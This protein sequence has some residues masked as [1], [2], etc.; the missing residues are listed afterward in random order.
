M[1]RPSGRHSV[2]RTRR[3]PSAFAAFLWS[4]ASLARPTLS[5]KRKLRRTGCPRISFRR[6]VML[7]PRCSSSVSRHRTAARGDV[8]GSRLQQADRSCRVTKRL[9][10]RRWVSHITRAIKTSFTRTFLPRCEVIKIADRIIGGL[11]RNP[12]ASSQRNPH[13]YRSP[14]F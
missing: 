7:S 6:V 9:P 1:A 11:L 5:I 13:C 2:N 10:S 3:R 8:S 14:M 4:A 12:T